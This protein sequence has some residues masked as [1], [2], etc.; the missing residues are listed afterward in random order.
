MSLAGIDCLYSSIIDL[1]ASAFITS[2]RMDCSHIFNALQ[3][4]RGVVD[5]VKLSSKKGGG[6]SPCQPS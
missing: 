2:P 6:H 5:G 3:D 1:A 4:N